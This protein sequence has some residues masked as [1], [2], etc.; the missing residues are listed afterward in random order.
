MV[1]DEHSSD[2]QPC[3][4]QQNREEQ[5]GP[6]IL[7]ASFLNRLALDLPHTM[8]G[9]PLPCP[10]S[11][12][13]QISITLLRA[14]QL[15]CACQ[16][17]LGRNR[18]YGVFQVSPGWIRWGQTGSAQRGITKD[19]LR[20]NLL[21]LWVMMRRC[22]LMRERRGWA[23]SRQV[24]ALG[25]LRPGTGNPRKAQARQERGLSTEDQQFP[26]WIGFRAL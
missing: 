9:W 12:L 24:P 19:L 6:G 13:R 14:T 10:L 26:A 11:Q 23:R 20:G 18:C 17:C 8:S 5:R 3:N 25:R 16:S 21:S 15:P 2:P 4:W 7:Q 22:S 1:R